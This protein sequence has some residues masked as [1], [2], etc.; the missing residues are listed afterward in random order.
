MRQLA[1]QLGSLVRRGLSRAVSGDAQ[2]LRLLAAAGLLGVAAFFRPSLPMERLL[3]SHVVVLDVTQSMNVADQQI[4]GQ[5]VSR[6]VFAKAALRQALLELPC[7]SKVGWGL[8]T[9]YRSYLLFAPVEV[10]ANL[11]ELRSTLDRIDTR[12]A[13]TGNS[14]VAKGVFSGIAMAKQL[15]GTPS[16][17]F[18]TDGQEAPPLNPRHRPVFNDKPGEVAGLLVGVGEL[19][20]SPIP[21]TDPN[22]RPLGFW[23]ADEVAQTD[24]YSRGRG[25]SVGGEKM[26]EDTSAPAQALP[27]ATPGSEHLSSLREA[28]LRLL[29]SDTGL[30]FHRLLS[31][32]AFAAVLQAP[33]LARPVPA[34]LDLRAA[35]AG[36][37]LLLLLWRP[38]ARVARP[39]LRS[40]S[41]VR[42]RPQVLPRTSNS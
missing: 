29:A 14:E 18:I 28:Y 41:A 37:A 15:P 39:L 26:A 19:K 12:M 31:A 32:P 9:E 8:F 4:N 17:V 42:G 23:G 30:G 33:G 20:P 7:G 3:F 22:G 10:C 36:L 21:K 34:Q 27:G 5:P 35:C 24:P 40:R 25:G 1:L 2:G 11:G 38:L 6:L 16:F 13:W